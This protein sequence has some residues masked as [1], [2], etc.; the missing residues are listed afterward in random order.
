M[1]RLT[2]QA[3]VSGVGW[4]ESREETLRE[5]ERL[6]GGRGS[7]GA[8]DWGWGQRARRDEMLLW[9]SS[10]FFIINCTTTTPHRNGL[11]FWKTVK[12]PGSV[13]YSLGHRVYDIRRVLTTHKQEGG[14]LGIH[15]SLLGAAE[16]SPRQ[17]PA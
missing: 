14:R 5:V 15:L 6:G 9:S 12:Q 7:G 2:G 1:L 16:V 3:G 8:G 17:S 10:V 13:V 4:G 11:P